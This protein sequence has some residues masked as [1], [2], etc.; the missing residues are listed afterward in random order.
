MKDALIFY[1]SCTQGVALGWY[2]LPL[3]GADDG[4]HS[5]TTAGNQAVERQPVDWL[6]QSLQQHLPNLFDLSDRVTQIRNDQLLAEDK[7]GSTQGLTE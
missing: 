7:V 6:E 5:S 4:L 3:Q 1:L 2:I